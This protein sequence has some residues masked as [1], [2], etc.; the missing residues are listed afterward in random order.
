M[1]WILLVK[2]IAAHPF[3]TFLTIGSLIVA[4]FL[5]CFLK[6]ALVS[7]QAGVNSSASNRLIVQSAVSLFVDLPLNYQTKIEGIDGVDEVCKFQWFGGLYRDQ[8]QFAQFGIDADR[9]LSAYPEVNVIAGDAKDLEAR[10]TA[11][12]IGTKMADAF[13]FQVGDTIPIQGTIFTRPENEPW[14]FDV[15][16][17]YESTSPNVDENTMFF[18]WDYLDET[19][20]AGSAYGPRGVGVY[21]IKLATGAD[22]TAVARTVDERFA[23]DS[24]R[25]QTTTEAEFQ[26]QFVSMLGSVP[27]FLSSIGGGVLFAIF[28]AVLNT[29]LMA[30]RERTRDLGV[31]KA[32]GF[33]NAVAFTLLILESLLICTIGGALGVGL[34]KLT[35]APLGSGLRMILPTYV[36]G[37]ET[38]IFGMGLALGIG[39]VAGL[40]P[41]WRAAGLKPVDALRSEA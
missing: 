33:G 38:A 7:L 19:L 41:A 25:V 28:L 13:G 34:A 12:I 9:F 35:E 27:T 5:L 37:S 36:I 39:V 31:L 8:M 20:E 29:M 22:G 14:V 11:C 2:N 17:I 6:T 4:V 40:A 1:P 16:A 32:L 3:R 15:V 26:R 18:R 10:R 24:Q 21:V 30:G 23:N